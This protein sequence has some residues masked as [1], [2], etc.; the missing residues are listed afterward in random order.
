M[1]GI[2]NCFMGSSFNGRSMTE[3]DIG[4]LCE[5]RIR[6]EQDKSCE[7]TAVCFSKVKTFKNEAM[8][9]IIRCSLLLWQTTKG[10]S[11]SQKAKESE[12]F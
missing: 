2:K 5:Q 7:E 1:D 10:R 3:E 12:N 9:I 11:K 6:N 8:V 4:F